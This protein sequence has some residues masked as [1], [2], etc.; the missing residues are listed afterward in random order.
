MNVRQ[1]QVAIAIMAALSSTSALALVGGSID[2]NSADSPWAGVG[3]ITIGSGVYSGVLLDSTHVLTAAHVVG[4]QVGTASNVS[5]SLNAGALSQTLTASS[6]GVYGGFIPGEVGAGPIW[7]D[8]LAV[9]TLS[10]PISGVTG[11]ALYDGLLLNQTITMVGFGGTGA[12]VK[13]VGQ[14]VVDGVLYDEDIGP[15]ATEEVFVFDFDGADP[16]VNAYGGETLGA[17]VEAGYTGGDSGSP[18]FVSVGGVWKIAGIGIFTGSTTE[19]LPIGGGTI[20][21]S[22]IPWIQ[23]QMTAPVPEPSAWAM[24]LVGM[25]LVGAAVRAKTRT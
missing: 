20:V 24:M 2:P 11:Y 13:K 16:N 15:N 25:G 1:K 3:S 14:N 19:G 23:D 9:I 4:G 22:Y 5:F 21:S 6:I 10:T 8:D 12:T 7:H 18:V 17:G